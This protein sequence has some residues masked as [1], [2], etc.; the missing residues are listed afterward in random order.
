MMMAQENQ[1]LRNIISNLTQVLVT[2][3]RA[4]LPCLAFEQAHIAIL[5]PCTAVVRNREGPCRSLAPLG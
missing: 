2:S 4:S 1:S 5:A 3:A